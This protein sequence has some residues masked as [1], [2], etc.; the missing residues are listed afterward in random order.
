MPHTRAW[1]LPGVSVY[2]H[3]VPELPHLPG[4]SNRVGDEIP[5]VAQLCPPR[6][7]NKVRQSWSHFTWK[8]SLDFESSISAFQ[9]LSL[10]IS[11]LSFAKFNFVS[12][13]FPTLP[14]FHP[15]GFP[16]FLASFAGVE[17]QKK[18]KGEISYFLWEYVATR[19]VRR[20]A[21]ICRAADSAFH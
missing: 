12:S 3:F 20:F 16:I 9:S 5:G 8:L 1:D 4:H 15:L 7:G 18:E 13:D 6:S 19:E 21:L 14:S 10:G 2:E 11:S 17:M